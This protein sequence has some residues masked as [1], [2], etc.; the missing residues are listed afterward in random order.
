MMDKGQAD[1]I[2]NSAGLPSYSHSPARISLTEHKSL[3][4]DGKGHPWLWLMVKSRA[5]EAKQLPSLFSGDAI[6]GTVELDFDKENSAKAVTVAATAGVTA[7]GQEEANFLNISQTLWD[8]KAASLAKPKGKQT[9][10]FSITL[11]SEAS[12][13]GASKEASRSYPLP[14]SFSERASPAYIEYR[15][16]VTV[17]RGILRVNR[18]LATSLVYL[19]VVQ[20]GPPSPLRQAAYAEGSTLIGPEGDPEGWKV[21]SPAKVTGTLFDSRQVEL[22]CTLAIATPLSYSRG[23][24]IPLFLTITS[25]D[26]QAVDLL[27]TPT[28]IKVNLIRARVLGVHATDEDIGTAQ[29]DHVFRETVGLAYFWPLVDGATQAGVRTLQGE[30]DL[31]AS[32]KPNFVFPKFTLRYDLALQPLHAP[33][34][35]PASSDSEPLL[36]EQVTITTANAAGIIPRSYAPPGYA[37]P[38][39]GD[40]NN[41]VGYLENGNQRFLHHGGGHGGLA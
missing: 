11:P 26:E 20:A 12:A 9:W 29:S 23:S 39:E 1:T 35:T 33:G 31:K 25:A 8:S 30:L 34:F 19:P 13:S 3:L 40:Y 27:A 15:L 17:R 2:M 24:P 41:T 10:A 4:E 18:T 21:L 38:E 5:N 22:Q 36:T 7:V 16:V 28:S 32:L 14:P 6:T 37:Q